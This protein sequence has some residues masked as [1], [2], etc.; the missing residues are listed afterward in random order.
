[1]DYYVYIFLRQGFISN[2]GVCSGDIKI[3]Q[4]YPYEE[5]L[6]ICR[7]HFTHDGSPGAIPVST[8][9]MEEIL[10]D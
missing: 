8:K 2:T 4:S 7:S 6:A 3:A 10:H 1:M 9:I 5:A